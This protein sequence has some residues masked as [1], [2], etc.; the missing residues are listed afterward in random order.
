MEREE[1]GWVARKL[2][3]EKTFND[4][5]ELNMH[6]KDS[7]RF[8]CDI[9]SH[10]AQNETRRL[11][12]EIGQLKANLCRLQSILNKQAQETMKTKQSLDNKL[13]ELTEKYDAEKRA[14]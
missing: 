10:T 14:I 3:Y 1:A 12:Q 8:V 6:N 4:Q 13:S 2:E 7:H 5:S 11:E 9:C